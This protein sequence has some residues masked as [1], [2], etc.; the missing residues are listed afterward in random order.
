M[1]NTKAKKILRT[2]LT[3]GV[4]SLISLCINF[5]LT[6]Y[7]TEQLG[8]EAYGFIT[9]ANTIVSYAM[10]ITT[11][12]NSFATRFIA[13]EYHHGNLK[14]TSAYLS[15]LFFSNACVCVVIFASMVPVILRIDSVL[16]VPS[17]LVLDVQYLFFLVFANFLFNNASIAFSSA[18]YIKN[19][20]D[21]YGIFQSLAYIVQAAVLLLLYVLLSPSVF[22]F[23]VGLVASGCVLLAGNIYL[24]R[25]Y[26]PELKLSIKLFSFSNVKTLVVN[27][28]WNSINQL[29]NVLNNGLSLLVANIFLNALT[30]GQVAIAKTFSSV[31]S[32]LFQ[33]VSQSFQPLMLE[34]YSNGD[35]EGLMKELRLSMKLS[36]FFGNTVFA[37]FFALGLPFY[38]LWIPSQDI[39]LIY[40]LTLVVISSEVATAP[41]NPLYYIYTLAVKNRIPCIIT[42]V[43][44]FVS[45][46]LMIVFVN[47]G[48]GAYA[49]VLPPAIVIAFINIVTNPIYMAHCLGK[50]RTVFYPSLVR[51]YLAC[52]AM[53]F[54]YWAI[55]YVMQPV[56]WFS[57]CATAG[58]CVIAGVPT[59]ILVAFGASERN[60]IFKKMPFLRRGLRR[61]G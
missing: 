45:V 40:F 32:R 24:Y 58:V 19:R 34:S 8:A 30:M 44:G 35:D 59:Y 50:K 33:L 38:N 7:V 36:A 39:S 20:L 57:F 9:L 52:A 1:P 48:L 53:C 17:A 11:A 56:T 29:G 6:P 10:I 14:K 15:S 49:V 27:G 5:F 13:V 55:A 22:Y 42:V 47:M 16:N 23:G 18:A 21:T 2:L 25:K 4:A 37:G 28:I 51:I 46:G 60:W 43:G 61:E 41:M 31:F 12:L 26:A 3:T 54:A